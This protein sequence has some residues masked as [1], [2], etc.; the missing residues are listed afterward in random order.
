M[1][2]QPISGIIQPDL[3][4][5]GVASAVVANGVEG[6]G[7]TPFASRQQRPLNKEAIQDADDGGRWFQNQVRGLIGQRHCQW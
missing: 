7:K 6:A 3:M 4:S 5:T 1:I 2:K